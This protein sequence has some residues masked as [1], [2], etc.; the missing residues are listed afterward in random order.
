MLTYVFIGSLL[1]L[2]LLVAG[3]ALFM[4]YDEQRKTKNDNPLFIAASFLACLF[5]PVT[6]LSVVI[7]IQWRT[8]TA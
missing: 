5:W 1:T 7:A 6:V 8:A 4:T 2:Y 3:F